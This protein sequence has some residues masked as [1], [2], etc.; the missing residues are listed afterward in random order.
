[1]R[2]QLRSQPFFAAWL[3]RHGS[4]CISSSTTTNDTS[5]Q[6]H[7]INHHCHHHQHPDNTHRKIQNPDLSTQI[8]KCFLRGFATNTARLLPDGS[9]R[10]LMGHQR[11]AIHPSSVLFGKKCE[12]IM[13]NEY[14]YTNRS[15]AKGVSM[16]QANWMEEEEEDADATATTAAE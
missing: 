8:L 10:T 1:M 3:K 2:K 16:I 11:V 15:Y 9:Y 12:A 4:S 14:V 7:N 5:V 6:D 13:Y